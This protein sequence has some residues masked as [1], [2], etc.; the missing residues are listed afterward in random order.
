MQVYTK[1]MIAQAVARIYEQMATFE[2][3][4]RDVTNLKT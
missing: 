2:T 1:E 4:E 3:L